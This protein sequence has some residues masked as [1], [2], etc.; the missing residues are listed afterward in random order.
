[1]ILLL[2][3]MVAA[4]NIVSTLT[5]VVADKT[6]EIG[7]LR[8]MGLRA[9]AVARIFLVQGMVIGIVGTGLG[10]I[11][12]VGLALAQGHYKFIKLDQTV[13]FID[14]LPV[15]LQFGD[16]AL[17][18]LMSLSIPVLATWYPA[19]QASRLFPVE[20]IRHE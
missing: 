3:M 20:A 1:V 9:G 14:H 10:L 7:I 11:I 6:R 8:A 13:Y 15:S 17:I 18:L 12:G 5:M 16:V 19:R 2:I 4:F